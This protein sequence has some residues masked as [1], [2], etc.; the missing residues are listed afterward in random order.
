MMGRRRFLKLCTWTTGAIAMS[1]A[2]EPAGSRKDAF[3]SSEEGKGVLHL[4]ATDVI[5]AIR[6]GSLSAE[7]YARSLLEQQQRLGS[8]DTVISISADQVLTAARHVDQQRRS[9]QPLGPLAGLPLLVKDNIDAVGFP[10]TAGTPGLLRNVPKTNAPVLQRLLDGGA[11]LFA[12]A[13]MHELAFGITSHNYYFGAVR[14]PYDPSLIPGGSSGG[15]AAGVAARTCPAALGTD[16]GGSVRIPAALCGLV[17]F[18]PTKGRYPT[19]R[20]VPISHTRDTPGPIT[21]TVAD[22]A[23]LDAIETGGEQAQPR[24]LR[25]LRL[26]IPRNPFWRDLDPD[27]VAVTENALDRLREQGVEL[28]EA[29]IP[30]VSTLDQQSGFPIALF[31]FR[32]DLPRYLANE[33]TGISYDYVVSHIASPDVRAAVVSAERVTQAQYDQAIKVFR[34][35]LQDRYARYFTDNRVAAM[36]MPTTILPARPIGEDQT[37]ALNGQQVPTFATYIRNT[38]ADAVAGIP[39]LSVPVGLTRSGLPVGLELDGPSGSDTTLLGIG[40]ALETEVF[41]PLRAPNLA[42]AEST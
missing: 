19:D 41:R 13:N 10:T 40:R 21:R 36:L 27:V 26:G 11:I 14:N 17:G 34:P 22:A 37:V 29:D 28:V 20:I 33:G 1:A 15:P 6:R 35:E 31:E 23:L 24:L 32:V 30:E 38:D 3:A 39:G 12:K 18:R 9:G 42:V 8:L 5:E 7:D 2:A 25:G 4:T 16:T